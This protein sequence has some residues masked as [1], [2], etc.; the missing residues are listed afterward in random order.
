MLN[1]ALQTKEQLH[2]DVEYLVVNAASYV[3]QYSH[4]K[5]KNTRNE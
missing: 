5:A 2:Y 3:E 4:K 1:V